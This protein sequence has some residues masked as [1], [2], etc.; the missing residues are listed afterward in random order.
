MYADRITESMR[1]TIEET[2]RRR[3]IQTE[4]NE[5]HGITLL[6]L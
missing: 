6:Q 1:K 4:Y 5:K 3:K 2:E